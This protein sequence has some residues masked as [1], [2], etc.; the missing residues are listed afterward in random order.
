MPVE[1]VIW[2]VT[3][4]ARAAEARV[5]A[6]AHGL[7]LRFVVMRPGGLDTLMWSRLYRAGEGDDLRAAS[8]GTLRD[9]ERVGWVLEAEADATAQ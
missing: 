6:M 5:R 7:E 4:D 8:D 9:F 2:R 3:K 1:R